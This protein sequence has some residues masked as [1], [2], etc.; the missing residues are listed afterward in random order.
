MNSHEW[1]VDHRVDF[2]ARSLDPGEER[3]FAEHLRRCEECTAGVQAIERELAWLPMGTAPA[4]PRP[5]LERRITQT[6]LGERQPAWRRAVA[7]LAVAASLLV[8]LGLYL[9]QRR[10]A[11]ALASAL[12]QRNS[13]LMALRDSMSVM[14]QAARVLQAS[15]S[16]N[17]QEG[18]LLIFADDVSHRWNVVVHGLPQPPAGE[19]YQFWFICSDGMVRGATVTSD[20]GRPAFLT[21]GMPQEGGTVMGASLTVEPVT[22]VSREPR[23]RPLA[24]LM[25]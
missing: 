5:G 17:G 22:N 24:K 4:Q 14:H 1:Y 10:E 25:L 18:G 9:P 19:Q 8:T 23:G 3:Q 13:E 2:I 21:L 15:I 7:P 11:T 12:A 20:P 16:F 6:V